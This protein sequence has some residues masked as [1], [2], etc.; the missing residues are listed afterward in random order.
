MDGVLFDDSDDNLETSCLG[1]CGE[2]SFFHVPSMICQC[3]EN[4]RGNDDCCHD[5]QEMCGEPTKENGREEEE[6]EEAKER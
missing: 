5:Y 1:R 4:C 6:E 3:D 2:Y